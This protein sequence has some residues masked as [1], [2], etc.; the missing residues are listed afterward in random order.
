MILYGG[1]WFVPDYFLVVVLPKGMNDNETGKRITNKE[2][3]GVK[4]VGMNTTNQRVDNSGTRN[5]YRL[6]SNRSV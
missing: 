2:R 3:K 4:R 1:D 6:P 5:L